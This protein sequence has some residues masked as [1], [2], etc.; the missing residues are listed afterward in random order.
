MSVWANANRPKLTQEQWAFTIVLL[1]GFVTS[2]LILVLGVIADS[3]LIQ[4]AVFL[5][6]SNRLILCVWAIMRPQAQAVLQSNFRWIASA[7]I[8]LVLA[9]LTFFVSP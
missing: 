9:G 8:C 7:F 5:F 6:T 2:T 4:P 1:G 3:R